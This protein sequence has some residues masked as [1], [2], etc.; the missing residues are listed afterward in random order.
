MH[1]Y[2][3]S[4]GGATENKSVVK[5]L[6]FQNGI[7]LPFPGCGY[8]IFDSLP[9]KGMDPTGG[10]LSGRFEGKTPF[11]QPRVGDLQTG[12]AAHGRCREEEVEVEGSGSQAFFPSPVAARVRLEFEATIEQRSRSG[13]PVN[14]YGAVEIVGLRWTDCPGEPQA[15]ALDNVPLIREPPETAREGFL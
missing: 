11:V 2:D 7:R 8:E 3:L 9:E 12:T 13:R 15:R 6:N 1:P 10:H 5:T 4:P 14:H